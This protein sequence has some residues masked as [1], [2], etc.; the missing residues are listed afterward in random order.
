M[1]NPQAE[2]PQLRRE[3]LAGLTA[4]ALVCA[5]LPSVALLVA[6]TP[7]TDERQVA[8]TSFV[9]WLAAGALLPMLYWS[10]YRVLGFA[11][12]F[13][14]V[15]LAAV[16]CCVAF[17]HGE[18][19][20][21]AHGLPLGV[22]VGALARG[23]RGPQ[24]GEETT[25]ILFAAVLGGGVAWLFV[26][27][28]RPFDQA[29]YYLIAVALALVVWTATRLFRPWFELSLEPLVWLA[30]AIRGRGPGLA[31]FPRTGP[32]LVIANHACWMDPG[33]L[34]KVIPRPITPMM[35]AAF[36]DLPVL[37]RIMVAF[38]VIR[39]PEKA[40]KRDATELQDAIAA[41]DRG[42][43]VVIFPEGYLRRTEEQP[44]RRYG[45][46][47]WQI[48]K[49]RPH[50][51]VFACWIEGA[52]GSYMSYFNGKPTKNKP[53]DVRR[54]ILVA[55]AEGETVP[56]DVLNEHLKTRIYLMNR[57]IAARA[58]LGLPE[59]PRYEVP[60]KG[61]DTKPDEAEALS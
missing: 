60:A 39:V 36:Y 33:F 6:D 51:P 43:C 15:W 18:W 49:A 44:L 47:V 55:V 17:V 29:G 58:Y 56:Q 38:G 48:L 42:E 22:I 11:T 26:S 3:R 24:P 31:D 2:S 5:A 53:R 50:T 28:G 30:Y 8:V 4:A 61:E 10:R 16:V 37:R 45:Q 54:P 1:P 25:A 9:G 19:P 12:Y 21:W 57:T 20:G 46:G 41:L 59:L 34:G 13:A 52:W 27:R 35:T 40:I 23:R 14:P 32:C 7:T